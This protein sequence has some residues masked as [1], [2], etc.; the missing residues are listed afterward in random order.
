[1][2]VYAHRAG[3]CFRDRAE[4]DDGTMNIV[5]STVLT[6][7]TLRAFAVEV[8]STIVMPHKRG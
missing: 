2:R 1:V 7:S 8:S 5:S 6:P 4:G 3:A